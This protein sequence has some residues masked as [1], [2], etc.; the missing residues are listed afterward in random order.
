MESVQNS[1][2]EKC[3]CGILLLGQPMHELQNPKLT[4]WT[5]LIYQNLRNSTKA[6]PTFM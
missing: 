6:L 2:I 3:F 1:R 4:L 5:L